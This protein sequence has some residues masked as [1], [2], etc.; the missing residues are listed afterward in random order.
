MAT[1]I[2]V[3]VCLRSSP[4]LYFQQNDRSAV[5][6]VLCVHNTYLLILITCIVLP[7]ESYSLRWLSVNAIFLVNNFSP[8]QS[9]THWA[10]FF[11]LTPLLLSEF[12]TLLNWV[13]LPVF[14]WRKPMRS[15][16]CNYQW[17]S[18]LITY[19]A[20]FCVLYLTHVNSALSGHHTQLSGHDYGIS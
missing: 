11:K 15:K 18:K 14:S 8:L 10:H 19:A 16:C 7:G 13:V 1:P 3:S 17:W 12:L 6:I 20:L 9:H 2:F 5:L 4:A